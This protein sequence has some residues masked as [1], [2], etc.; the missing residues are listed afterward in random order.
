MFNFSVLLAALFTGEALISESMPI[1]YTIWLHL[2][3]GVLL[4]S[5]RE[6]YNLSIGDL[7]SITF[8]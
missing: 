5:G 8:F 6:N 4:F 7:H 3:R 1:V 2:S